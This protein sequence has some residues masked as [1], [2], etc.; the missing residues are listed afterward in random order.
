[1]LIHLRVFG[2]CYIFSPNINYPDKVH[3]ANMGPTWV[4]PTPDKSIATN[5]IS[6][7]LVTI[8]QHWNGIY[9][10]TLNIRRE[11]ICSWSSTD[12][13]CS[14]ILSDQQV[15]CLLSCDYIRGL[16]VFTIYAQGRICLTQRHEACLLVPLSLTLLKFNLSMDKLSHRR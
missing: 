11:W 10:Q 8:P 7:A 12:R 6:L 13:L 4:L 9:S 16:T 2:V 14:I 15:Y 5:I 3:G 1:M